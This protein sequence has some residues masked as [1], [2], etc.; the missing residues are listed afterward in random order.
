MKIG[1]KKL[2]LL[3]RLAHSRA[4]G[5]SHDH[6]MEVVHDTAVDEVENLLRDHGIKYDRLDRDQQEALEVAYKNGFWEP[7]VKPPCTCKACNSKGWLLDG[8][9]KEVPMEVQRCDACERFTDDLQAASAF[10]ESADSKSF[11]LRSI[12]ITKN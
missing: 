8:D 12:T 11:G 9:G 5:G 10:F 3:C 1:K 4:A 2:E 6:I 7:T